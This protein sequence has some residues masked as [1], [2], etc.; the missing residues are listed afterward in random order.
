MVGGVIMSRIKIAFGDLAVE[1]ESPDSLQDLADRALGLV[2]F[3][4]PER[5][6]MQNMEPSESDSGDAPPE[7]SRELVRPVL[8]HDVLRAYL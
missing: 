8:P 7:P 4:I 6:K 1:L 5:L 3:L 2:M